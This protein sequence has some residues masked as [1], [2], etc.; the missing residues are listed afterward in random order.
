M[1]LLGRLNLGCNVLQSSIKNLCIPKS[2]FQIDSHTQVVHILNEDE[3]IAHI[4]LL[5]PGIR[6]P[7]DG[8]GELPS[9]FRQ[10]LASGPS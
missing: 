8:M 3:L 10:I 2:L 7:E 6:S 5:E 9:K 1:N 4:T